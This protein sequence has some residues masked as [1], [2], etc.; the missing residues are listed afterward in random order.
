[1]DAIEKQ[2]NEINWPYAEND[3]DALA[4]V[5]KRIEN[6]GR[7]EDLI[8]YSEL[9]KGITFH[10][11][12]VNKGQ[13]FQIDIH[14]WSILD[15]AILGEFLGYISMLSYRKAKFMASALVI[16]GKSDYNRP[17][18]HFFD[19]MKKLGILAGRDADDFWQEQVRKAH[20]WFKTNSL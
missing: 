20:D 1:M 9:V 15:R 11:P 14:Q 2:M 18:E 3:P 19:W 4:E 10:L 6:T 7:E 13:P 16:S 17:S 5:K 8:T 12:N